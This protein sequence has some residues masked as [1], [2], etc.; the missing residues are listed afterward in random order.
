MQW[1]LVALA[2]RQDFTFHADLNLAVPNNDDPREKKPTNGVAQLVLF[3]ASKEFY[4]SGDVPF[5]VL[6]FSSPATC[7]QVHT[8][9]KELF[10]IQEN[11][12]ASVTPTRG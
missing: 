4:L 5:H 2:W 12:T 9:R 8:I 7:N 1:T 10:G 11:K 6:F 3:A